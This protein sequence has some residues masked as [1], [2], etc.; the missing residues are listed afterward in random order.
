MARIMESPDIV[1][2]PSASGE[3]AEPDYYCKGFKMDKPPGK[4]F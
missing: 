2:Q 3:E 1:T 4:Q